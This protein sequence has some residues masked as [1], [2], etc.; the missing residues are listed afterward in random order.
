MKRFLLLLGLVI[1]GVGCQDTVPAGNPPPAPVKTAREIKLDSARWGNC[2]YEADPRNPGGARLVGFE[3]EIGI[4]IKDQFGER[5]KQSWE[6]EYF[7]YSSNAAFPEDAF[8]GNMAN[9]D[10]CYGLVNGQPFPIKKRIMKGKMKADDNGVMTFRLGSRK[11]DKPY[12]DDT[13]LRPVYLVVRVIR[14]PSKP[15]ADI[16]FGSANG[17]PNHRLVFINNI[18]ATAFM[19]NVQ[20]TESVAKLWVDCEKSWKERGSSNENVD[21]PSQQSLLVPGEIGF[22]PCVTCDWSGGLLDADGDLILDC[23]DGCPNDPKKIA[24][25]PCGCGVADNDR[26]GDGVFDC[27]DACPRNQFVSTVPCTPYGDH[28]YDGDVDAEDVSSF[29]VC[30]GLGEWNQPPLVP[31]CRIWDLTR[32]GVTNQADWTLLQSCLSRSGLPGPCLADPTLPP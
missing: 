1:S 22:P 8:L 20:P 14:D 12:R 4:T 15:S 19:V 21:P 27:H 9:N 11:G 32:D 28:D 3:Y 25:G 7:V 30:L 10:T 16:Y 26:D 23:Q 29:Q 2:L 24:P 31:E 5:Y 17:P 18:T 13:I 6:A